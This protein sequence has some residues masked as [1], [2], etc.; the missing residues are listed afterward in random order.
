MVETEAYLGQ[1]IGDRTHPDPASHSVR[2]PT[3]SNRSMFGTA[4]RL[5][6]YPIHSRT[7]VNLVTEPV[8]VG[9]A[10]LLRA[11]QPVWGR[12]L[13]ADLRGQF[14]DRLWTTGPGRLCGAMAIDRR[15]DGLDPNGCE[16]W[17][18]FKPAGLATGRVTAGPRIGISRATELPY[19][20]FVD[21]NRYVSG[22]AS[23]HRAGR[24]GVI[25][26]P[27]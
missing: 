11:L 6:V 15:C 4:G 12:D 5:Y 26:F 18:L 10:V 19:R 14:D 17:T 16:D 24:R 2:G 20:F 27:P 9:A 25:Q 13:M 7:C 8:S 21:G 1:A 22:P 23:A 3:A